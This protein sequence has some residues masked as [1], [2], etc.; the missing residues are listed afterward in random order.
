MSSGGGHRH[1]LSLAQIFILSGI[2]WLILSLKS[3]SEPDDIFFVLK[4]DTALDASK[5]LEM[6]CLLL[7]V[8]REAA[9]V[10][11]SQNP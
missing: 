8:T 2:H 11:G 7:I 9:Q 10:I 6:K 5:S 3:V 4:N 1:G